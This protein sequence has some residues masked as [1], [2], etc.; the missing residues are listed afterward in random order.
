MVF[1]WFVFS[2]TVILGHSIACGIFLSNRYHI[3]V[4]LGFSFYNLIRSSKEHNLNASLFQN[5]LMFQ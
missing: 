3:A 5:Y 4:N 1:F 2:V